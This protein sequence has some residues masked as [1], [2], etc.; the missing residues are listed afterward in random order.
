MTFGVQLAKTEFLE[1]ARVLVLETD[2]RG[3][4]VGRGAKLGKASC[5]SDRHRAF[6]DTGRRLQKDVIGLNYAPEDK[7]ESLSLR[8]P[9]L[10]KREKRLPQHFLVMLRL[11]AAA[12][13][14]AASSYVRN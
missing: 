1:I 6:A 5:Q 9:P 11:E 3:R 13:I 10:R 4:D 14:T 12:S 7:I 8:R 2:G